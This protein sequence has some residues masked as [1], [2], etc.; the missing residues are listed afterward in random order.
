MLLGHLDY[1][2]RRTLEEAAPESLAVPSGNRI[3]L[4]YDG[5]KQPV[6][7]VRLQEVFGW[8]ETPRLAGGRVQVLLHLLGP[9]FR[10][11]QITSDLASFW[12]ST[13]FQVRKDLRIRYPKHSWPEDPHSAKAEAKGRP[14]FTGR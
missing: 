9:N 4:Q 1:N 11:V 5:E 13:Y 14:R 2:L 12:Q 6:L 3:R 7:E 8:R 10:P